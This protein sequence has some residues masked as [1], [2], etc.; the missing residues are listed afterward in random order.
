[1]A[2]KVFDAYGDLNIHTKK[3]EKDIK[4]VGK[5]FDGLEKAIERMNGRMSRFGDTML[6]A[7]RMSASMTRRV[8]QGF[9]TGMEASLQRNEGGLIALGNAF[10]VA[11]S[12]FRKIQNESALALK[13]FQQFQRRGFVLQSTLGVIAGTLGDLAGGFLSLVGIVSQA[14]FAF[15]GV[16]GALVSVVAGFAVAKIAMSGVGKAVSQLWNGQNQYNRSLRDARKELKDL[17]FDLEGAVLSEKEAAIELEKARTQLAMAQDLPPDNMVRREAEL[18]YQRADLNYRRAKSRVNDLQDTIKRGGNAAARAANA[19]PFKNLTKSQIAFT[20]YLVTLKPQLQALKE[21]SASSFLPPLQ[22]AIQT[23][24]RTTFPTLM[25]GFNLLGSAMGYAAN[26]FANVFKSKENVNLL[27]DFFVNSAPMIRQMGESSGRFLAGFLGMLK[28]A[29]P[30]TERFVQAIDT[31][32]IKLETMSKSAQFSEFLRSAGYVASEIG[33]VLKSFSDG[34]GN[35]M[36]ANFP[37]GGGGAGQVLLDFLKGIAKGFED[38]TGSSTFPKWLKDTT[39]NATVAVGVMGDFLG[40][41]IDLAGRPEVKQFW[42]AL[43]KSIPDIT[44]I[45][46]DGLKAGPAFAEMLVSVIKLFTLFSDSGAL[47]SFFGTLKIMA[48]IVT[49]LL[50]PFKPLID[51]IG[52][53]HGFVLAIGLGIIV[54]NTVGVIF[55]AILGKIFIFVGQL[56]KGFLGMANG[57]GNVVK[58]GTRFNTVL[59]TSERPMG[60]WGRNM[61]NFIRGMGNANRVMNR[62]ANDYYKLT[63]KE[64]E[65]VAIISSKPTALQRVTG[66]L[67]IYGQ[68][69]KEAVT[70][71]KTKTAATKAETATDKAAGVTDKQRVSSFKLIKT[72]FR[73]INTSIRDYI[74]VMKAKTA[75]DKANAVAAKEGLATM[76]ATNDAIKRGNLVNRMGGRGAGAGA[77]AYSGPGAMGIMGVGF[78]AEGLISGAANGGMT[79]GSAMTALGG[80]AMFIPGGMIPGLALAITGAIVQ[81]FESAARAEKEKQEQINAER[82]EMQVQNAEITATKLNEKKNELSSL[83]GQKGMTYEKAVAILNT[84]QAS[85]TGAA[86]AAKLGGQSRDALDQFRRLLIDQGITEKS[87]GYSSLITA[88]AGLAKTLSAYGDVDPQALLQ[89]IMSTFRA[90][91]TAGLSKYGTGGAESPMLNFVPGSNQTQVRLVDQGQLNREAIADYQQDRLENI[92]KN[93]SILSSLGAVISDSKSRYMATDKIYG[94]MG[95]EKPGGVNAVTNL[96]KTVATK[97]LGDALKTGAFDAWIKSNPTIARIANPAYAN[98]V[99]GT[100]ANPSI[101]SVKPDPA[102]LDALRLQSNNINRTAVAMDLLKGAIVDGK[103][104]VVD[105]NKGDNIAPVLIAPPTASKEYKDWVQAA[106]AQLTAAFSKG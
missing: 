68:A 27:R 103:L 41:F 43:A 85:I 104:Q 52:K 54:F 89:P 73:D 65:Y 59:A 69:M 18:A 19:D 32:S 14:A 62:N 17:K 22:T 9:L 75:A 84:R 24:V 96:D 51:A 34:I 23:I 60:R 95:K 93:V 71:T 81:G 28:A 50:T 83:M 106:N 97:Y 40:I 7:D 29:Q 4:N 37:P 44:K 48:D 55:M 38:F 99:L 31:V 2:S 13:S 39:T 88:G 78:A 94:A 8:R 90:S 74:N 5:E 30:L 42:E 53:F 11:G 79:A 56:V 57:F 36:A 45:L 76:N 100:A 98:K 20:K 77:R 47:E 66:A 86:D 1:M 33:K 25:E 35:I 64:K 72:S 63:G 26:E 10:E 49:N 21:A 101:V 82:I 92:A 80:A 16:G 46:M 91:G 3:A 61:T 12:G 6:H 15:A 67:K 58:A 105:A 102:Q 70:S 87:A